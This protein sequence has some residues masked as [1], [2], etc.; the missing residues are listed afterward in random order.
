[1]YEVHEH[2]RVTKNGKVV[3]SDFTAH[4]AVVL[5]DDGWKVTVPVDDLLAAVL[6][7]RQLAG[8]RALTAEGGEL[9]ERAARVVENACRLLEEGHDP[10]REGAAT[11]LRATMIQLIDLAARPDPALASGG[12]ADPT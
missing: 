2:R 5:R 9:A 10:V 1:M 3:E 4:D 8:H 7:L 6:D 12:A 11:D